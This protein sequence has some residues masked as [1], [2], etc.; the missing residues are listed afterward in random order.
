MV[1]KRKPIRV[2]SLFDGIATGESLCDDCTSEFESLSDPCSVGV[3]PSSAWPFPLCAGLLVLRELGI[4]VDRYVASEVCED[5]ITVGIV[6]HQ[7]RIMYVGDVRNVTR[8]HVSYVCLFSPPFSL[9]GFMVFGCSSSVVQCRT[10]IHGAG[11]HKSSYGLTTKAQNQTV[12]VALTCRTCSFCTRF[13]FSHKHGGMSC[14]NAENQCWVIA[15]YDYRCVAETLNINSVIFLYKTSDTRS[16]RTFWPL[17]SYLCRQHEANRLKR[18]VWMQM[19]L[20]K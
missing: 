14:I 20:E 3:S 13:Y 2:L 11:F 18:F 16:S 5:S 19:L 10:F 7:G 12:K 4:E 1:E 17:L 15:G 6:R 9:S 8:K